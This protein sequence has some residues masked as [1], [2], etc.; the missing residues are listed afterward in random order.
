M[1]ST[2]LGEVGVG[3]MTEGR[4]EEGGELSLCFEDLWRSFPVDELLLVVVSILDAMLCDTVVVTNE[5][6]V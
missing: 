6:V 1:S 3:V 4:T 2:F 5:S